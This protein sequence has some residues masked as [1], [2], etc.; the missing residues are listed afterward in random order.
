MSCIQYAAQVIISN[1]IR[2]MCLPS[3]LEAT[4]DSLMCDAVL[5]RAVWADNNAVQSI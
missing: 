5:L 2:L 1:V 4:E 3:S